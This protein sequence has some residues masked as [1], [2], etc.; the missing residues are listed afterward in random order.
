MYYNRMELFS[1][2]FLDK[3]EI[4]LD[5]ES[6]RNCGMYLLFTFEKISTIKKRFNSNIFCDSL[7][8]LNKNIA[9]KAIS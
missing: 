3:K 6:K 5:D 7:Y 1:S 9:M 4:F 2:I 8:S